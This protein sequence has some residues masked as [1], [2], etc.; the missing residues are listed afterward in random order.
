MGIKKPDTWSGFQKTTTLGGNKICWVGEGGLA[1]L[2]FGEGFAYHLLG[3]GGAFATLAGYVERLA[4]VAVAAATLIDCIADLTVGD[5]H[6][7]ANV[8]KRPGTRNGLIEAILM[9][10]RMLVKTRAPYIS[11]STQTPINGA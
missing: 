9:L 5:T 11:K 8:H 10:M 7:K 2:H 4:N 6:A 1:A 3:E